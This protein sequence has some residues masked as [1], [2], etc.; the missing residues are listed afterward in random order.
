ML[1]QRIGNFLRHAY[2][3]ISH[4]LRKRLHLRFLNYITYQSTTLKKRTIPK[5]NPL[6]N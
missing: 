2:L 4:S 1:N 5:D 3:S 6:D